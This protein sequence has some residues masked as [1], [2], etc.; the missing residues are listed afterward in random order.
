[1]TVD[2]R[3]R[4]RTAQTLGQVIDE[5][6][7]SVQAP[8]FRGGSGAGRSSYSAPASGGG[9]VPAESELNP[10]RRGWY[11]GLLEVPAG[12]NKDFSFGLKSVVRTVGIRLTWRLM[13][14][15]GSDPLGM[16]KLAVLHDGTTPVLEHEVDYFQDTAVNGITY[17]VNITGD[18]VQLNVA[19]SGDAV[20]CWVHYSYDGLTAGSAKGEI[21]LARGSRRTRGNWGIIT[22]GLTVRPF[23][24]PRGA[25]DCGITLSGTI[26]NGQL[27]LTVA[28]DNSDSDPTSVDLSVQITGFG[29]LR[30]TQRLSLVVPANDSV[31]DNFRSD[32]DG[33]IGWGA[34]DI[35]LPPSTVDTRVFDPAYC[36]IWA[37]VDIYRGSLVELHETPLARDSSGALIQDDLWVD[38]AAQVSFAA[39]MSGAAIALQAE[40]DP[41]PATP[42]SDPAVIRIDYLPVP[43]L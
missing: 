2:P 23:F 28:A 27:S 21:S 35:T 34:V 37:L 36:A 6:I 15:G 7:R 12:G 13:T 29:G 16:S 20:R 32:E 18:K 17:S 5:R 4:L 14:G 33:E 43:A 26:T 25:D 38:E 11:G 39:G 41:S 1:M 30:T 8:V 22:D 9:Q 42:L 3:R 40:T 24:K 19:S 10:S 31:S